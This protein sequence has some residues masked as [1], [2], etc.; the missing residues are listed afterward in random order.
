MKLEDLPPH[1]RAEALAQ[2]GK[3]S[4]SVAAVVAQVKREERRNRHGAIRTPDRDGVM[5]DSKLEAEYLESLRLLFGPDKVFPQVSMEVAGGKRARPDYMIVAGECEVSSAEVLAI[6]GAPV[7]AS[8]VIWADAK[9]HETER[10]K[11][12]RAVLAGRG[13]HVNLLKRGGRK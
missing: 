11:L 2:M 10:S 4:E 9:G 7:K 5:R 6:F 12:A 3:R 1:H 8:I 13:V